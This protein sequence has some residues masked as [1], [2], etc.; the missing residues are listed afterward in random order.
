MYRYHITT[1]ENGRTTLWAYGDIMT[2]NCI[3]MLE[4]IQFI[5]DSCNNIT[6]YTVTIRPDDKNMNDVHIPM[7]SIISIYG[8]Y[9]RDF[10]ER[11]EDKPTWNKSTFDIQEVAPWG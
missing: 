8:M 7:L 3:P 10:H 2:N 11:L 9:R 1:Y 5:L 6:D 4:V